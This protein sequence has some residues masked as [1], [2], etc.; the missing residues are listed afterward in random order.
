MS[1]IKFEEDG[2]PKAI[3]MFPCSRCEDG[4]A[5]LHPCLFLR[6][7]SGSPEW[8]VYVCDCCGALFSPLMF[9]NRGSVLAD[10]GNVTVKERCEGRGLGA[11]VH[12]GEEVPCLCGEYD[13]N[14]GKECGLPH[15]TWCPVTKYEAISKEEWKPGSKM[16]AE[17]FTRN[18]ILG[19]HSA[20]GLKL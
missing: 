6:P 5:V 17:P 19:F 3:T 7:R 2:R 8:R 11:Q 10:L 20:E 9:S 15:K 14:T 18:G 13:H 1:D 16:L 4:V 12:E